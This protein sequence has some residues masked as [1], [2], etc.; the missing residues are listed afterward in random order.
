L[1][2]RRFAV[3]APD[4]LPLAEPVNIPPRCVEMSP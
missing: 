4:P 2:V 1:A 3:I